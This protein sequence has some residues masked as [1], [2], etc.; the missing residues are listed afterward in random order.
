MRETPRVFHTFTTDD[1][2]VFVQKKQALER[3]FE[4][5]EKRLEAQS[6]V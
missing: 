6:S 4:H 2:D 1:I 5:R 3:A